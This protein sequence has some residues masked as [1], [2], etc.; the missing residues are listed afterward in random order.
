MQLLKSRKRKN[1]IETLAEKYGA[2]LINHEDFGKKQEFFKSY[3]KEF[4]DK[5]CTEYISG[6]YNACILLSGQAVELSLFSEL[7][8]YKSEEGKWGEFKDKWNYAP[9]LG[10]LKNIHR[11]QTDTISEKTIEK[12]EKLNNIRNAYAHYPNFLIQ[13]SKRNPVEEFDEQIDRVSNEI[14]FDVSQYKPLVEPLLDKYLKSRKGVSFKEA[15]ELIDSLSEFEGLGKPN[16]VDEI[17]KLRSERVDSS[18]DEVREKIGPLDSLGTIGKIS[19]LFK[20]PIMLKEAISKDPGAEDAFL[21]LELSFEILSN[22]EYLDPT[23]PQ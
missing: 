18:I 2:P 3:S 14:G 10:Q 21:S 19:A 4:L 15:E 12:C 13:A 17:H 8:I 11:N 1:E 6:H 16:S 23:S 9:S 5:A 7:Y 22:L 20:L